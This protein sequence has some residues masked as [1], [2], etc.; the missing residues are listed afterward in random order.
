MNLLRLAQMTAASVCADMGFA[1]QDIEDVR[2]AVDELAAL[3]IEDASNGAVLDLCFD[4]RPD[5]L[6]VV[7]AVRE[8]PPHLPEVNVVAAEL[9][10]LVVDSY[11]LT[12]DD[13]V[14]TFRLVK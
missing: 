11:E 1:I 4:P 3:L 12:L 2:V 6:I 13:G 7:G 10:A 9:L 5:T 14:R 8:A